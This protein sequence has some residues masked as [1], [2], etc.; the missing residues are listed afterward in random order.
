MILRLKTRESRSLPGLLSASLSSHHQNKPASQTSH[1][2]HKTPRPK[3]G[4]SAFRLQPKPIRKNPAVRLQ[5]PQAAPAIAPAATTERGHARAAPISPRSQ[6]TGAASRQAE[7]RLSH[8]K[9]NVGRYDP[10]KAPKARPQARV[11]GDACHKRERGC[12]EDASRQS[13]PNQPPISMD[14]RSRKAGRG[15]Y[16]ELE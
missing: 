9:R 6:W 12:S 14:R 16:S 13:D 11:P 5:N 15:G 4:P 8:T 1:T 10:P 7:G 2:H 3:A